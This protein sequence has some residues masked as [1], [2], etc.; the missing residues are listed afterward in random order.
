MKARVFQTYLRINLVEIQANFNFISLFYF[1]NS[2]F[3]SFCLRAA[4]MY[5]K[6]IGI[7]FH[8]FNK[9]YFARP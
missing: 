2:Q 4:K 1:I 5:S 7:K 8:K 9:L 3:I 6:E